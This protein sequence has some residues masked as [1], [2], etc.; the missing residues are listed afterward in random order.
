MLHYPKFDT[1]IPLVFVGFKMAV[2]KRS[3]IV[4]VSAE[5]VLELLEK[6]DENNGGMSGNEESDLDRQLQSS[7]DESR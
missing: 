3:R 7:S 5:R 2:A 1:I 6:E 4:A